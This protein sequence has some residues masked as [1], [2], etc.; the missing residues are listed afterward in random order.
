MPAWEAL[1]ALISLLETLPTATIAQDHIGLRRPSAPADLP[2][3]VASVGDVQDFPAGIG[4][5]VGSHQVSNTSWSS[6]TAIRTSGTFTVELWAADETTLM[7]LATAV[8]G[9]LEDRAGAATAGFSRLAAASAGPMNLTGLDGQ[10]PGGATGLRLPIGAA[11]SF[12]A[13]TEAQTGPDGIINHVHVDTHEL[14]TNDV[15]E[16]MDLP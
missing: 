11:F 8:T 9:K 6:D 3:V 4:G 5:I 15:N 7:N 1:L 16:A 14:G 13:V 12:E 2:R 10:Q